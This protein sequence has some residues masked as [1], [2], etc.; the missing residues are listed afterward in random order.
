MPYQMK[1]GNWKAQ[2]KKNGKRREQ[3]FK[4][5][6]EAIAWES[7]LRLSEEEWE[8]KIGIICLADWAEAYLDDCQERYVKKTYT[9]KIFAFKRFFKKVDPQMEAEKLTPALVRPYLL[10]E[11]KA[12]SGYA[13]NKDRKNLLAG[14]NWGMKFMTQPLTILLTSRKC[15]KRGPRGTFHQKKIFGKLLSRP[16]VKTGLCFRLYFIWLVGVVNYSG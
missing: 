11:K 16:M 14:W 15:R 9:E 13:S 5:K 8:E 3:T 4:T 12:R 1:N 6:K 2:V 7:N 10:E